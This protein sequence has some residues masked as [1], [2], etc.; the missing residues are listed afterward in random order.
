MLVR[1]PNAS[2]RQNYVRRT[3]PSALATIAML[4]GTA[5]HAQTLTFLDGNFSGWTFG[6]TGTATVVR[7]PGFGISG[8][9]MDPRLNIT[10]TSGPLVYGTAYNPLWVTSN[11]L[12]G[13]SYDFSVNFLSGPGAF[14]QGQGIALVIQQG[15]G[16]YLGSFLGV[17]GT[18][19]GSWSLFSASGT[20]NAA[21]FNLVGGTGNPSLG[22][23]IPTVFG[24]AGANGNSATLT[25]YYD[26][27]GLI[28]RNSTT[29]VPEP[30][31]FALVAAGLAVV[32]AVSRRRARPAT[33]SSR[34]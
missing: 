25:N 7:E 9:N 26:N 10:T 32:T 23:G 17:T 33:S 12:A 13:A 16:L 34:S 5:L 28:V 30:A 8:G 14:G 4:V 24:F 27:A 2:V 29:T 20:F 3:I 15:S 19:F 6:A 21:N 22:G 1:N 11:A 18:S 31:S